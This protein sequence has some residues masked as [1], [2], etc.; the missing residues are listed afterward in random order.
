MKF[1]KP[2]RRPSPQRQRATSAQRVLEA[3]ATAVRERDKGLCRVCGRAI[4]VQ[5]HHIRYRSQGGGHETS[6]LVC[7]CLLCHH[8]VHAGHLRLDGDPDTAAFRA[9]VVPGKEFPR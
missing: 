7:L 1:P 8:G 4:G 3:N 6:N 2:R 5:V 9:V